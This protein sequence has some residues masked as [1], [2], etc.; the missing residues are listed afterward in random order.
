MTLQSRF[1]SCGKSLHFPV[2]P[3]GITWSTAPTRNTCFSNL[4]DK[5]GDGSTSISR[6][7]TW[8]RPHLCRRSVVL[9]GCASLLSVGKRVVCFLVLCVSLGLWPAE[10]GCSLIVGQTSCWPKR[11][12][13]S[14]GNPPSARVDEPVVCADDALVPWFHCHVVCRARTLLASCVWTRL[15]NQCLGARAATVFWVTQKG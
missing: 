3:R 13:S 10:D 7:P 15:G 14:S 11:H 9:H 6:L 4:S 8:E 2:A 5:R 1:N 12:A